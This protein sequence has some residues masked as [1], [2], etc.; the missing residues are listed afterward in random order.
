MKNKYGMTLRGYRDAAMY[1]STNAPA[2]ASARRP[3][4]LQKYRIPEYDYPS[5]DA[6]S[7]G[8]AVMLDDGSGVLA[9]VEPFGWKIGLKAGGQKYQLEQEQMK[10]LR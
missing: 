8:G 7:Q 6:D 4:L 10:Q 2:I 1:S 3:T 5:V 9:E